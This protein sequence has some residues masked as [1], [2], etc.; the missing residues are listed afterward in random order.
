MKSIAQHSTLNQ[1]GT[2]YVSV[3][4]L[5][6][7]FADAIA[8]FAH[9]MKGENDDLLPWPFTG[10]VTF[11]LLNQLEDKNHHSS[12]AIFLSDKPC[13]QR[14]VDEGRSKRIIGKKK[15]VKP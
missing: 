2:S 4:V 1:E 11:E 9:L 10:K 14:V 3:F 12:S 7:K 8:V 13:S 5:H 6:S 15:V